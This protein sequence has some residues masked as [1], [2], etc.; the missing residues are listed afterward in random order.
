MFTKG[1]TLPN[2]QTE[3]SRDRSS[4]ASDAAFRTDVLAFRSEPALSKWHT[5]MSRFIRDLQRSPN[6]LE[7]TEHN[8]L[9]GSRKKTEDVKS[10]CIVGLQLGTLSVTLYADMRTDPSPSCP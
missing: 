7:R 2:H 8:K 9:V 10:M 1:G 6:R 3:V 5:H 4:A